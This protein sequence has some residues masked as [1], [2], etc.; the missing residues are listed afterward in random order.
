MNDIT[1]WYH[2]QRYEQSQSAFNQFPKTKRIVGEVFSSVNL[3]IDNKE[4]RK[5]AMIVGGTTLV[6][7][8]GALLFSKGVQSFARKGLNKL[9]D[10]LEGK[11]ETYSGTDSKKRISFY[12]SSL[13]RINS[14]IQ[15]TESINNFNS[16]KDILFMRLMY[17]TKPTRKIHK[18]ISEFFEKLSINTVKSSYKKTQKDFDN[19]YKAFDKL[20]EHILKSSPDELIE[21]NGKFKTKRE[22]VEKARDYRESVKMVVG[23]FMAEPTQQ[24]RYKYIKDATSQLYSKFW[25]ES[26]KGFWTKDNKFK[27]KE[28]WQTFIASE[29]IKGNKTNLAEKVAFARNM[30]S[31]TDSEK[32]SFLSGYVSNLNSLISAGDAEGIEIMKR[33]E[34]LAKDPT[35]LKDNK[36]ALLRELN[37]LE[38]HNISN[39]LNSEIAKTHEEDKNTNIRLIRNM[40]NDNATGELQDM[41]DIYYKLA[42]FELTKSGAKSTAQKAVKSFDKSVNLE[43]GELF[44]KE[45][46]LE[47]GSAPTDILTIL[48]SC[49]MITYGIGKSKTAD[50]K[51]SVMLKSGIPIVGA[52]ATSLISATKLVSG[53]KSIALGIVSG[54]ILNRMGVAA[55]DFRKGIK[56]KIKKQKSV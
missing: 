54:I 43:I 30:L 52:V 11:L 34:W 5:K 53:G 3:D 32:V 41:L 31:Y 23:S 45:R 18:V 55:D 22:L 39:G 28:M 40:V 19:M 9:K 14:F 13:R 4:D 27:R 2:N 17:K 24:A 35:I 33:V 16:V 42:P 51:K 12:E 49:G 48:F 56:P 1:Q 29:Q 8:L 21:Y 38:K 36:E 25:E 47:I 20:D 7:G 15:K 50:E 26:F 37:K 44:D 10:V 6:A 46:D